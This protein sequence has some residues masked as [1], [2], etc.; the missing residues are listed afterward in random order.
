MLGDLPVEF[1]RGPLVV[2]TDRRAIDLDAALVLLRETPWARAMSR[3]TL[4]RAAANSVCFTLLEGERLLGFARAVTDLATYAYLT[5]V[6]VAE[7]HRGRGL[8]RWLVECAL[9]HPDMQ[10]MRRVALITRNAVGL[11][12]RLGF[13]TDTGDALYMERRPS[14]S[15]DASG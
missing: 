15:G 4:E 1:R 10:G 6:V 7:S 11:Y 9:A 3:E 5:D 2:T 12:T 13:G 14:S 8:G